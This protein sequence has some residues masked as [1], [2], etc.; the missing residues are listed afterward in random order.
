MKYPRFFTHDATAKH[1]Q[2]RN[3]NYLR[4]C[5]SI[6]WRFERRSCNLSL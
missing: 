2:S 3:T 5:H 6:E 4:H 1:R